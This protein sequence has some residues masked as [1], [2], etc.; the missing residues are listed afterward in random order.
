MK[1]IKAIIK[2]VGQFPY[3]EEIKD[4]LEIMQGI[5]GGYIEV[6]PVGDSMHMVCNEDGIRKGL[7]PNFRTDT[8]IIYG[9]ILFARS[10]AGG[11]FKNVSQNDYEILINYLK[12]I[13][14][15][16]FEYE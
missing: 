13:A 8:G 14:V 5:V 15:M 16:V 1:M 4:D 7:R 6:I 2:K 3:I 9:D 10:D 12:Y 11:A